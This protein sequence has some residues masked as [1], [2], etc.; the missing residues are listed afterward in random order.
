MALDYSERKAAHA[1]LASLRTGDPVRVTMEAGKAYDMFVSR[2]LRGMDGNGFGS[3]DHAAVTVTFG[4]GRM[5]REVSAAAMSDGFVK[6]E[7][8]QS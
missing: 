8:V 3:W 7:R 6:L 1:L 4:P 2:E 5:S